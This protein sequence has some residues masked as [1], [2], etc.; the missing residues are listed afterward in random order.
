MSFTE[1]DREDLRT[2]LT[3]C[4]VALRW[5]KDRQLAFT[6]AA[7]AALLSLHTTELRSGFGGESGIAVVSFFILILF[8]LTMASTIA[9]SLQTRAR[10]RLILRRLSHHLWD[11]VSTTTGSKRYGNADWKRSIDWLFYIAHFAPVVALAFLHC[12]FWIRY[13]QTCFFECCSLSC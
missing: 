6:A 1:S 11:I 10:E 9:S 12:S 4:I 13:L 2:Y 7:V 5:L 8:S 3:E